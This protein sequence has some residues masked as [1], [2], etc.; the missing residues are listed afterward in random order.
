MWIKLNVFGGLEGAQEK[1]AG[2]SFGISVDTWFRE[3][4]LS[5]LG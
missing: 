4:S 5:P 2:H 1:I 3:I